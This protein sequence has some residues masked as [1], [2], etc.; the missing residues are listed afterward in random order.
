MALTV[1][2]R[3]RLAQEGLATIDDFVDFK[4]DQLIDAFKN[5]RIVIP[6][7]P[8]VLD[9]QGNV[10]TP[11]IAPIPPCLVSARCALRLKV[12]SIAYH[13]Y[14]SIGR[15][16]TPS[17]MNYSQVLRSFYVEWEALDKLNSEDKPD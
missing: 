10:V 5:M 17:N 4:E 7:V 11:A 2:Q 6:G 14:V 1:D 13:Y 8:A 3:N 15:D 9:D 12:A 16:P